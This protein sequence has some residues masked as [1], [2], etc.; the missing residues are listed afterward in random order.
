MPSFHV[1]A[2]LYYRML[3]ISIFSDRPMTPAAVSA[4]VVDMVSGSVLNYAVVTRVMFALLI[5][6][7]RSQRGGD[8]LLS[9]VSDPFTPTGILFPGM[10]RQ[11]P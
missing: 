7:Q 9:Q 3:H 1:W 5:A 2:L 10:G 6:Y 8:H 11:C 4:P